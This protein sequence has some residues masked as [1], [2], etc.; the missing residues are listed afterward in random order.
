VRSGDEMSGYGYGRYRGWRW[1]GEE[2]GWLRRER[3]GLRS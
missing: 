3:D 1:C 2:G